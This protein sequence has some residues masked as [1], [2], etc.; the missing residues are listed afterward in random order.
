[1]ATPGTKLAF[2]VEASNRYYR[3][4]L[5]RYRYHAETLC[6]VFPEGPLRVL[7]AG[8]GRGRLPAYWSRWAFE[9]EGAQLVGLDISKA[10]LAEARHKGYSLLLQAD[11]ASRWPLEDASFDAVVCEQVLEHLNKEQARFALSEIHRVLRP[12]GVALIGTPIFKPLTM[13][14]RFAWL[15]LNRLKRRLQGK[16]P[17]SHLQHYSLDSLSAAL[18]EQGF[19]LQST[20]GFCVFALYNNWLEDSER[21]YRIQQWIGRRAPGLCREI[22]ILCRK[23]A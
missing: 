16:D 18:H 1:M 8:C 9:Y 10:R 13:R 22:N 5:A 12:N 14:L 20:R 3:L 11:L 2:E 15:P 21:Y 4:R 23:P 6:E 17:A 19:L 7:D